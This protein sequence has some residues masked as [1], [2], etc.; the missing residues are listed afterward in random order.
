MTGRRRKEKGEKQ[1]DRRERCERRSRRRRRRKR[2]RRHMI[3][4]DDVTDHVRRIGDGKG[5]QPEKRGK[6]E[7]WEGELNREEIWRSSGG[8]G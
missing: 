2:G 6:R 7:E 8:A 4:A 5:E 1:E 3:T